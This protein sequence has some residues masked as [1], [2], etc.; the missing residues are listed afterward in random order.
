MGP[1]GLIIGVFAGFFLVFLALARV[2]RFLAS[3]D[4]HPKK[5]VA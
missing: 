2:M 3:E 4:E 1:L 5:P